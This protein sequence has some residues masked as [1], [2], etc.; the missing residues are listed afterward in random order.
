M[1]SKREKAETFRA[2]HHGNR[3]LVL[4]NAWDVPSARVFENC[5]FV[6]VATSS[7]GMM[8]SLGYQDGE[9]YRKR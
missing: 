4:P 9:V 5:G 2:L 1:V 3:L 7:A 6:A 8:V